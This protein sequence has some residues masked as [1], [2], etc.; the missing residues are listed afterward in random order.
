MKADL[1]AVCTPKNRD[2]RTEL[3]QVVEALKVAR[4]DSQAHERRSSPVTAV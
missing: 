3:S 4:S 2:A 1:T